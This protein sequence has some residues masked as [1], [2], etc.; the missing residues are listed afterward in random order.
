[1]NCQQCGLEFSSL[2][3]QRSHFKTEFHQYNLKRRLKGLEGISIQDYNV[4]ADDLE[5]LESQDSEEDQE[6]S[7]KDG[8][9]LILRNNPFKI[10]KHD[11][12][13]YKT[14]KILDLD[15]ISLGKILNKE[16]NWVILMMA[17]GHFAGGVF[18]Q[19]GNVKVSKTF[20]RYTTRRKQGGAQSGKDN[21]GKMAKSAGSTLRRYNE[22][23]LKVFY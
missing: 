18:D 4:L 3:E 8:D 13:F 1:M 12:N 22:A 20:H 2:Q 15:E 11:S 16:Y 7:E 21:T 9:I 19:D 17:S 5:S 6:D 14:F 10:I 23:A